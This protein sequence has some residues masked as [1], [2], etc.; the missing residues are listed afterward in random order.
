[1]GLNYA[2]VLPSL[3]GYFKNLL[4]SDLFLFTKFTDDR[5][6]NACWLW[7]VKKARMADGSVVSVVFS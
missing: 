7:Y 1:M 5:V 4:S 6:M 3:I 2:F